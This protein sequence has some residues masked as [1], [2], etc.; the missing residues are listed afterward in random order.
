MLVELEVSNA[1]GE[2]LVFDD[3]PRRYTWIVRS[4]RDEVLCDSGRKGGRIESGFFATIRLGP[5]ETFRETS[6][7]NPVCVAFAEAGRYLVSVRRSLS[8]E[9]A[10]TADSACDDLDPRQRAAGAADASSPGDPACADARTAA[11]A[12]AS[13]FSIEI[14]AWD[15]AALR[16]RLATLPAEARAAARAGDTS[17]EGVLSGYGG[18]LCDHVRCYCPPTWNRFGQWLEK[19][20]ARVP[21]QMGAGC[22]RR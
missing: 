8:H 14:D 5:G 15:A 13:R 3:R 19:A 11:P 1:G 12:V 18:W 16:A 10:F 22:R 21:E 6:L 4:E 7:L 17:R 2:T 20:I 9:G